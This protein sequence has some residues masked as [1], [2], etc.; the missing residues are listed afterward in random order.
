MPCPSPIPEITL[1]P[2]QLLDRSL[3]GNPLPEGTLAV[4]A[5]LVIQ[6]LTAYVFFVVAARALGPERYS[7]LSVLWTLVFFAAPGF[8]FPLEQ[9]VTRG[10]SARRAVGAGGGPVM[11]RAAV[12]GAALVAGLVVVT[13]LLSGPILHHLFDG[14]VLLLVALIISLPA[15]AGVYLARGALSGRGR[16]GSY[17]TLLWGEGTLRIV[18][19]VVLAVVGVRSTGAYG[20]LIALPAI[21]ALAVVLGRERGLVEPGAPAPWSELS[22]ALGWLLLGAVLSQGFVNASVP[23]VKVLAAEGEE[24]IAGQFQAGLIITRVPLFLFQAVQA[25]LL[26]KLAGLAA[27]GMAADFRTGLRRLVIVVVAIGVAATVGAFAIGPLVLRLAFGSGFDKLG[28]ADLGFLA[29]ASAAFMLAQA[30]SQALIALS[31]HAKAA[32]GWVVAIAVFVVATALGQ[33][34]LPRVELGL[35]AGSL[36]GVVAMALLLRSQVT[37]GLPVDVEPLLRNLGPDHGIIEP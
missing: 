23:L 4:G 10:V 26:P 32:L 9:E 15:Y 13:L 8:L 29:L 30:L 1:R 12:L 2:R 3:S 37:A 25:S 16:F 7:S 34:L 22:G 11:R 35:V 14:Q 33:G 27:A 21:V 6:G 18:A 19:A 28:N 20:L 31:A 5:G 36:A 24:A 17:G